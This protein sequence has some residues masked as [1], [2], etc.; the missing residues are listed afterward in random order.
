MNFQLKFREISAR[1]IFTLNVDLTK[2]AL[3]LFLID[4]VT[5][6]VKRVPSFLLF[7]INAI[8]VAKMS[9]EDDESKRRPEIICFDAVGPSTGGQISRNLTT[10]VSMVTVS[11]TGTR[12]GTGRYGTVSNGIFSVRYENKNTVPYRHS[13]IKI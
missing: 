1:W 4:T 5:D 6:P 8:N 9:T 11:M 10:Q 7:L 3:G 12:N 13:I 2:L